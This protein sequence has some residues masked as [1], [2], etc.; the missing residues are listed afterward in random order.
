MCHW[1]FS[2]TARS[3]RRKK[4]ALFPLQWPLHDFTDGVFGGLPLV[5][6]GVDL[7][8]D[9]H[10]DLVLAGQSQQRRGR[11]HA[12]G[13]HAHVREDLRKAAAFAELDADMAVPAERPGASEDKIAQPSETAERFW[14]RPQRHG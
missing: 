13:D 3:Q 12:F 6:Y 10:F 5:E 11:F 4:D 1:D 14:T 7:F 8:G 9:G 2:T